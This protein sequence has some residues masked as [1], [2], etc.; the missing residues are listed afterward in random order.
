MG[1][2]N[3][4]AKW[5]KNTSWISTTRFRISLEHL[6]ISQVYDRLCLISRGT[7]EK[8][9]RFSTFSFFV[10]SF[11]IRAFIYLFSCLFLLFSKNTGWCLKWLS[12][13][14]STSNPWRTCLEWHRKESWSYC[15]TSYTCRKTFTVWMWSPDNRTIMRKN[16]TPSSASPTQHCKTT[17]GERCFVLRYCTLSYYIVNY[18]QI[19]LIWYYSFDIFVDSIFLQA[20]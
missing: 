15:Q 5:I 4:Y 16:C 9:P 11:I 12:V 14:N 18:I 7:R 13:R 20:S 10:S 1:A 6:E 8:K 17:S 3:R 19:R 2:L